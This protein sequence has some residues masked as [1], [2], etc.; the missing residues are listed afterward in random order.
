MKKVLAGLCVAATMATVSGAALAAD[1]SF[2]GAVD[3]G[4]SKAKDLCNTGGLAGVT[5]TSCDDTDTAWRLGLGYQFN[6]NFGLEANYVDFGNGNATGTVLGVPF[7][8]D[9]SSTA[10]QLAVTGA[11]PVSDSFAVTG[12]IGAAHASLD[13]S[14]S[15]LGVTVPA[16]ANSTDLTYGIG[17]R[18]NINKTM[19]IRA[20][21]EAQY[22]DFGKVGDPATTGE[23][24]LSLIS[25][26]M[27]FGF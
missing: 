1:N 14:A 11:L 6:Q 17:V 13:M 19:A 24:K 2:Y 3:I 8:A 27:T 26:G 23:S 4:Q 5:V 15:A 20:Q 9:A 22:E 10:F 21:Y 16:S 25:I 12:K 18:Y 7:T